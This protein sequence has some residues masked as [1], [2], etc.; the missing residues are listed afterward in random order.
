MEKCENCN[1]T[2]YVREGYD[3]ESPCEFCN[4]DNF[5][6]WLREQWRLAEIEIAALKHKGDTLRVELDKADGAGQELMQENEKLHA[7]VR[8]QAAAPDTLEALKKLYEACMAADADGELDGRI[9]GEI[10]D[11]ANVAIC[12]AEGK[13]A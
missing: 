5:V 8:E 13:A 6:N 3:G 9:N 12:N 2:G 4:H 1:G 7:Q 11:A 10:L